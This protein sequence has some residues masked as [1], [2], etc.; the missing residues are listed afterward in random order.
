[1]NSTSTMRFSAA[2]RKVF[3]ALVAL[4]FSLSAKAQVSLVKWDMTGQ[5][6]PTVTPSSSLVSNNGKLVS[7]V[8][9]T[10]SAFVTSDPCVFTNQVFMCNGWTNLA[11]TPCYLANFST[12]NYSSNTFKYI[13]TYLSEFGPRNFQ[14]QY[15]TSSASGPWTNVGPA[16]SFS[17][18]PPNCG[19][20]SN[21]SISLPAAC[22]NLANVWVRIITTDAS[23]PSGNTG[24]PCWDNVEVTGNAMT[25]PS[26]TTQPTSS[27]V[28]EG[29]DAV[30]SLV[31]SN[32]ITYKWQFRTSAA[33]T[34]ADCP[35]NAT[36]DNETT[37]SLTVNNVTAAMSGYQFRCIVTGGTT[38]DATSNTVTMTVNAYGTWN[39]SVNANWDN[40]ANWNCNQVPTATT[41]VTINS[42]GTQPVIN[43]SNATCANLTIN[44]GAT[45]SFSGSTNVLDVKG[46]ASGT[47]TLNGAAG[48]V[49][50]SGTGAQT[51]PGG[52]YK[53]LQMNGTG[54]KTL[55][56]NAT[57][58][59]ILTLTSG[60]ITLGNNNLTITNTGSIAAGA[61]ANSF[62]VT[63][64]TGTLTNQ[65]IGS[66]GK[67]GNINFP[68]G[69]TASS[70]TPM[71]INNT[72]GTADNFSAQVKDN[73]Y[74]NYTGTTGSGQLSTNAVNKTWF[75]NEGI[76]GG[77]NATIQLTWNVGNELPGFDRDNCK[78]SHYTGGAWQ[79][80]PFTFAVGADPFT[81]SRTGITS[82]SPFGVGSTA[83]PL[84]LDLIAFTGK[85][86]K[87]DVQ[88]DW[89]TA[90]EKAVKDFGIERSA[91]GNKYGT[92]GTVVA[93]NLSGQTAYSFTDKKAPST[94]LF[95]RLKMTDID[96][97]SS[98]STIVRIANT[99]NEMVTLFPNPVKENVLNLMLNDNV[100]SDIL[101]S[102]TDMAGKVVYSRKVNAEQVNGNTI[103]VPV[104][105]LPAGNYLLQVGTNGSVISKSRF[106]KQ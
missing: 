23:I 14:T 85:K 53:D 12:V 6:G 20:P 22:N 80:G 63:N 4:S 34:F 44:S 81:V 38:P 58:A 103:Q 60:T 106:V 102:I 47:G 50:F 24:S 51:I 45:L 48:K 94:A 13:L 71:V 8:G 39:G 57:V 41:N 93:K 46:T 59:G 62:V 36:Y 76:A 64:G 84:P 86:V 98:Y 90:N 73:V 54:S 96:G 27:T 89:T 11:N 3:F 92:I 16:I 7:A 77:S 28:C 37:A 32:A 9:Q 88:L 33:G 61:N 66:G 82:F 18:T 1:M 43:V 17:G 75:M 5:L 15:S 35:N 49:I 95:Y 29:A 25:A 97:A 68:I 105:A 10:Q 83:S 72:T 21:Q 104:K 74:T 55:G 69:A 79:A 70:Y 87:A 91:D 2:C 78:L 99:G 52:S 100:S 40:P 30:Y 65:N 42:G 56:G 67:T 101:L 26:I 31:A 19:T